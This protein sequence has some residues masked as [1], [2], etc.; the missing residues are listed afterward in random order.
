VNDSTSQILPAWPT[1]WP[2]NSFPFWWTLGFLVLVLLVSTFVFIVGA[3]V[4]ALTEP[5]SALLAVQQNQAKLGA[6]F[7]PLVAVQLAGEAVAVAALFFGLPWLTQFSLRELGFRA[8]NMRDIGI[9]L[10][11]AVGMVI[12]AD[13][14]GSLIDTLTHSKH[15]QVV[16]QIFRNLHDPRSLIFFAVF[17]IVLQPIVEEMAFRVFFFN[18]GLRYGGFWAG[19]ILSGLLFGAAHADIYAFV[20]LALGG[21]VLSAVYYRSGNAYASMISH[22]L[23]NALSTAALYYAPKFAGS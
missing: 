9:A 2:K 11:G 13:G 12:V 14:G 6:L 16:I 23:F 21:I 7:I 15:E 22:G 3:V 19:A 8:P 1:R 20:P 4:L 10:L 18:L 5:R 17:A